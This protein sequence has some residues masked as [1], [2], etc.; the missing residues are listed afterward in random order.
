ML[1]SMVDSTLHPRQIQVR[2]PE[3]LLE[4]IDQRAKHVQ[5]SRNAWLVKALAWA[6][7]QP[8]RA[9]TVQVRL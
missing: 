8:V 9:V 4:R 7:E 2:L 1:A 3:D 6:V 5:M